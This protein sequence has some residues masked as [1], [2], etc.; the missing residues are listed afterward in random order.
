[1]PEE[2]VPIT[3]TRLPAKVGSSAGQRL[4]RYCSPAKSSSPLKRG[5]MGAEIRPVAMMQNRADTRSPVSVST[6]QRWVLSSKWAAVTRVL[7]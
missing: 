2:P 3:V 1:M 5:S 6:C 4:V 7:N